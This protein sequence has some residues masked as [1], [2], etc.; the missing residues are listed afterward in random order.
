[1]FSISGPSR[2]SVRVLQFSWVVC[3]TGVENGP[4]ESRAPGESVVS[5]AGHKS[6]LI[7]SPRALGQ[8]TPGSCVCFYY[9]IFCFV[10]TELILFSYCS[11]MYLLS[12]LVF[13]VGGGN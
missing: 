3:A 10:K 5:L 11:S 2:P 13:Y 6:Q 8:D 4:K 12:C 1:M 9:L 7:Y